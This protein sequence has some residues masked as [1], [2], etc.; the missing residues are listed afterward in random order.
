MVRQPSAPIP[1]KDG[2]M[3][4]TFGDA[5]EM[6]LSIPEVHQ[7]A[8]HWQHAAVMY[9]NFVKNTFDAS[10]DFGNNRWREQEPVGNLKYCGAGRGYGS[11][12]SEE[13]PVSETRNF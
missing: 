7:A 9:C 11:R 6:M 12:A 1:L 13:R 8:L 5:R 3:L 10:H 2:R 4:A